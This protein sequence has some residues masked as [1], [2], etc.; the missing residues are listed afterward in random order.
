M[1]SVNTVETYTQS[2]QTFVRTLKAPS[3]PPHANG[4]LKIE[5][6]QAAWSNQEFHVPNKGEVIVEWILTKFLKEKAKEPPVNPQLDVRYW[7]LMADVISPHDFEQTRVNTRAIKTWLLPLLNRVPIAPIAISFLRLLPHTDNSQQELLLSFAHRLFLVLWPLGVQKLGSEVLLEC[8][9]AVLDAVKEKTLTEDFART[10]SLIV[11]SFRTSLSNSANKKKLYSIFMKNHLSAWITCAQT[12]DAS[13]YDFL[14]EDISVTGVETIFNLDILRQS[15]SPL[16]FFEAL[17][18]AEKTQELTRYT[19]SALPRLFSSAINALKKH[20]TALFGQG[21]NQSVSGAS[22]EELRVASAKVLASCCVIIDEAGDLGLEAWSA[23]A[24]L[25]RIIETERLLNAK[26]HEAQEVLGRNRDLAIATLAF[27]PGQAEEDYKMNL[28]MEVLSILVTIDHDLVGPSVS[29]IYPAI[30]LARPSTTGAAV[31]LLSTLIEHHSKTRTL[32][33]YITSLLHSLSP[34]S[35]SPLIDSPHTAYETASSGPLLSLSHLD[36]LA[37]STYGF[38]TPGQILATAQSILQELRNAWEGFHQALNED[39]NEGPRKK[40]KMENGGQ[41]RDVNAQGLAISFSLSARIV[42]T[43][44][45]SLPLQSA[46]ELVR[47]EVR[48]LLADAHSVFAHQVVSK[49]FKSIRKD[50]RDDIWA[51]QIV[52]ASALR[53]RYSLCTP[54]AISLRIEPK[55]ER[56]LFVKMLDIVG[57]DGILPELTLGIY[58]ALLWQTSRSE[59]L[60]SGAIFDGLLN[61][62]GRHLIAHTSGWPGLSCQLTLD[63]R[64][65]ANAALALLST[66]VDRWLPVVDAFST[67]QQLQQFVKLLLDARSTELA[68]SSDEQIHLSLIS[69]RAFRSAQFWELPNIRTAILAVLLDWTSI[70]DSSDPLK[71]NIQRAAKAYEILLHIPV[72]YL[73]RPARTDLVR[74]ALAADYILGSLPELGSSAIVHVR[75]FLKRVL[76]LVGSVDHPNAPGFLR[77]LVN[78]DPTDAPRKVS[79]QYTSATLEL[80]EIYISALIRSSDESIGDVSGT[81]LDVASQLFLVSQ[82]KP[83]TLFRMIDLI[84]R[85]ASLSTL[86]DQARISMRAVY[87]AMLTHLRPSVSSLVGEGSYAGHLDDASLLASWCRVQALH[88]WLQLQNDDLPQFG[89]RL[90]ANAVSMSDRGATE[91]TSSSAD[92]RVATFAIVLGDLHASHGH[93]RASHLDLT[94]AAYVSLSRTSDPTCHAEY[95][96]LM[97]TAY[98]HLSATDFSHIL[99]LIVE[100]LSSKG[101]SYEDL[102]CIVHLATLTLREAPQGTLRPTQIFVTQ[103]LHL[104]ASQSRFYDGD[105]LLR[106]DVLDFI[107]KHVSDRPAAV[108]LADL[109]SVWSIVSKFLV[110]S[111]HHDDHTSAAIF[112]QIVAT[113]SALIRLR[114]D[115][116]VCTLPHLS[117]ILGQLILS[118][119][120]PRPQLGGKQSRL[121]TNTMPAWISPSEPLAAEE[122]KALARLLTVLTTKSIARTHNSSSTTEPQKAESLAKPFSKHAAYVLKAYLDALNDPLCFLSSELRRELQPGLFALCGMISDHSRDAMMVSAL[123]AGGKA[124]MK[125]IWRE[126]EK[127]KYVGKG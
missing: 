125:T 3:D 119:R 99:N 77:H 11:R 103:S 67:E 112:H 127:Q 95:D 16:P 1:A 62:I 51:P 70:F 79:A 53:F 36:R 52:A 46:P 86:P 89:A 118:V 37:K 24:A 41:N 32:P 124:A 81:V 65:A 10:A 106:L 83:E 90:L 15:Q 31:K 93:D 122:G 4:P 92:A 101:H 104:F 114:R 50:G 35:L 72:E 18:E 102:V 120:S 30:L 111:T 5:I 71:E 47:T 113:I 56:K 63:E 42:A 34:S 13:P 80:V 85:D 33:S 25:L 96:L 94:L 109:S 14:W 6:A 87:D 23:R 116:V 43:V 55:P 45:S 28:A 17:V 38:M 82:P 22:M 73:S 108:R 19:L 49:M 117:M 44:L 27:S 64:G 121:V 88:Q 69:D 84:T 2:S 20:R 21:S 12:H 68:A 115:L 8:F 39:S 66:L 26:Q 76:S 58:R 60:E 29:L 9:G 110:G 78:L 126:Y 54:T 57:G 98:K 74:R 107:S 75:V 48:D 59:L 100:S 105:L 123:D 7:S 97:S 40:R 91:A 61:Y